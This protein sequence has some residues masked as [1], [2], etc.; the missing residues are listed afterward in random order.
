[1]L[2]SHALLLIYRR[3]EPPVLYMQ[4]D[5][6]G[7]SDLMPLVPAG[8]YQFSCLPEA[9]GSVSQ[10]F[11]SVSFQEMWRMVFTGSRMHMDLADSQLKRLDVDALGDIERLIDNQ[12][13]APDAFIPG[14]L[15]SG[16]F[17]GVYDRSRLVA[18]SGTHVCSTRFSVAAVGNVFTDPEHRGNGFASMT[19]RAVVEDL[20]AEGIETIVL[21]VAQTNSPAIRAYERIGFQVHRAYLEGHA[22]RF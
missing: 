10:F 17:Y 9:Q 22:T 12:K 2:K 5:A 19:T 7:L 8:A 4:G 6:A 13:D 18:L 14:Q 16:I 21:N 11:Q 15:R 3:L 20:L 1:L